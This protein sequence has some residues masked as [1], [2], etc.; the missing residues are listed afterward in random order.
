MRDTKSQH[1][2]DDQRV[3]ETARLFLRKITE[4]DVDNL[5]LIF[6]DPIAMQYYPKTFDVDE[7]KA[8]IQRILNNYA[9]HGAGLWACHLKSTGEFV[10][11]CGLFFQPD[12][13]G[14]DEVEVGYLFV[15]KFWH[16]G[17]ATEAALG[18]MKHAREKLGFTRLVSLIRP[19]NKP[20]IRVAER[21]GLVPEKEIDRKGYKHIIYIS[22][23][24]KK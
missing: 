13:D 6:S 12:I 10:G 23:H 9:Q 19:E 2:N 17:F 14:R 24:H 20:S 1:N 15:R 5:Q 16:Q 4:N 18:T 21:N 7:T 22:E 11:Q 8:W 3:F